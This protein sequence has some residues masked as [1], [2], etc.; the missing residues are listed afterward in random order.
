M[1]DIK[2]VG[3]M[4]LDREEDC[5]EEEVHV[6]PKTLAGNGTKKCP[7]KVIG[8]P[9]AQAFALTTT[10]IY[11]RPNGSDKCGDGSLNK[12]FA[13]FKHAVNTVPLMPRP[14]AS[15]IVDITGLGTEVLPYAYCL[16]QIV[17]PV[18]DYP[19]DTSIPYFYSGAGLRIR[20]IPQLVA[21]LPPAEMT[22][23]AGAGAIVTSDPD[24]NLITLTLAAGRASWTLANLKNKQIIRTIG[25][26]FANCVIVDVPDTKTLKL[27][28]NASSFNGGVGPLVLAPGEDLQIVEQSATLQTDVNQPPVD[29]Y[30]D[31]L[32]SFVSAVNSVAFQGIK[33]TNPGAGFPLALGVMNCPQV[34][35]ELCYVEGMYCLGQA[36]AY[37]IRLT[38]TVLTGNLLSVNSSFF[39]R[40]AAIEGIALFYFV[41]ATPQSFNECVFSNCASIAS[42]SQNGLPILMNIALGNTLI[43]GSIGDS[44]SPTGDGIY[45]LNGLVTLD[46]V[47]IDGAA[48]N[49]L[50]I[51]GPTS[52][53]KLVHATGVNLGDYGILAD[54]GAR[55]VADAATTISGTTGLP[56]TVKAG[57]LAASPYPAGT[58]YDI[59]A[60]VA[61]GA[62]GTGTRIFQSP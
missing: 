24:T 56:A 19:N 47:K 51:E 13:T 25:S 44:A 22:I 11:V 42:V 6:D 59:T 27:T 1:A 23:G 14:G 45:Q 16:P 8:L 18:M 58:Q 38:G 37:W 20:A 62:T 54:D 39:A 46:H 21:G 50:R 43:R 32:G 2:I 30:N 41:N 4:G 52:S 61:G 29:E 26:Y 34:P 40:A 12:P 57:G 9:G 60:V 17:F 28:N 5:C 3:G 49:G 53:A 15:Y 33:I 31:S 36:G 10:T 55:V 7:L 48:G 35:I